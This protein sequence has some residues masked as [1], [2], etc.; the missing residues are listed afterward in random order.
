MMHQT[1]VPQH[2]RELFTTPLR[3]LTPWPLVHERTIPTERL[4]G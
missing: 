4:D 1:V 3:W 2:S